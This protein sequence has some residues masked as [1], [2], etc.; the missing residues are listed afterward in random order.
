MSDDFDP[1]VI[2]DDADFQALFGSEFPNPE[3]WRKFY[4]RLAAFI[5]CKARI[6][7]IQQPKYGSH[8]LQASLLASYADQIRELKA[9]VENYKCAEESERPHQS[10]AQKIFGGS[11]RLGSPYLAVA[12]DE[13]ERLRKMSADQSAAYQKIQDRHHQAE[14]DVADLNS[15]VDRMRGEASRFQTRI[16][17]LI[18]ENDRLKAGSMGMR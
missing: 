11:G 8:A 6:T 5:L 12:L 4:A 16:S 7:G 15:T 14:L 17:V 2:L 1:L 10:R 9:M 18:A 13:V 3:Y